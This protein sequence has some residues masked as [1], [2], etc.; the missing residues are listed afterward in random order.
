MAA[1]DT[2]R[3]PKAGLDVAWQEVAKPMTGG[4]RNEELLA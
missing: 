2:T 4:P 1:F 3:G